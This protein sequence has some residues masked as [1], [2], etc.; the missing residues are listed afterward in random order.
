MGLHRGAGGGFHRLRVALLLRPPFGDRPADRQIAM[1][2]VMGRGLVGDD[3]GTHTAAHEL[4]ED[5]GGICRESDGFRFARLGPL[6]DQGKR[7][8]QRMRLGIDVTGAQAEI[9]AGL[10]AFDGK[11][12]GAGHDGRQRLSA[13][14]ATETP[15]RIHLPLRLPL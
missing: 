9:D 1:D 11:A 4:R 8:V 5:V 6:V 12:A 7:L 2:G 14:H 10:I 13:T 15:V 3:V